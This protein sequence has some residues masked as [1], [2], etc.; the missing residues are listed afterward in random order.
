VLAYT[1]P[2]PTGPSRVSFRRLRWPRILARTLH[3]RQMVAP[4]RQR[5]RSEKYARDEERQR[6]SAQSI[7][8]GIFGQGPARAGA[9]IGTATTEHSLTTVRSASALLRAARANSSEPVLRS[10]LRG[11]HCAVTCIG[12]AYCAPFTSVATSEVSANVQQQTVVPFACVVLLVLRV[13]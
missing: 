10:I 6:G 8:S 7:E 5:G 1:T 4:E 9:S 12:Y 13:T 11:H 3:R 2:M